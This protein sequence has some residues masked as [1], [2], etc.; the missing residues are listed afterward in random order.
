MGRY[1]D[2]DGADGRGYGISLDACKQICERTSTCTAI[3]HCSS[4]GDGV[5]PAL[6]QRCVTVDGTCNE[7]SSGYGYT[8]YYR[9][10]AGMC[11]VLKGAAA[12]GGVL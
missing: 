2:T 1:C 11:G 3:Y 5:D 9:P 8:I 12:V 7:E 10:D 4:C 6:D